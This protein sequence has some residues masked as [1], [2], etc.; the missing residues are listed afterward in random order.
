MFFDSHAH[1]DDARFNDDRDAL[2]SSMQKNGVSGIA[3][4]G[5]D[6]KSSLSSVALAKK[7]DFVYAVVGVHPHDAES[8]TDATLSQ[9][10]ALAAEEKVVAIGEIGLDYYYDNSPRDTQRYWF[11]K[12]M[13][14]ASKLNMPVVIHS[15]DAMEDTIKICRENKVCGGVIHCFS[16][17]AESARIFLDMG[18]YISFAGPVTFKNAKALPE[19]AKIVPEDKILIETD[20]PYLSPEPHRGERNSS[21]NVHCVAEKLAEIRGVTAQHIARITTENAKRLYRIK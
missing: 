19:V 1:F 4:I 8:M 9:I 7:Y 5:A 17:S 3:N 18:Y 12:Q 15:R 21:L 10:A 13:K 2:L 20:S 14:L 6:L 11:K 16:G